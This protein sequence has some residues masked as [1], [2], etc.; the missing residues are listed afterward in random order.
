MNLK[1]IVSRNAPLDIDI[2]IIGRTSAQLPIRR[3]A[4]D[5]PEDFSLVRTGDS[6]FSLVDDKIA[7]GQRAFESAV[8][9]DFSPFDLS[10]ARIKCFAD[11]SREGRRA[12][13]VFFPVAM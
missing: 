6:S 4:F 7:D 3:T 11:I 8:V 9:I 1:P 2:E 13:I 10:D 5:I 12:E